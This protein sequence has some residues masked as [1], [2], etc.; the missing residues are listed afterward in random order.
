MTNGMVTGKI[1]E[2]YVSV[3]TDD[4]FEEV[5]ITLNQ[6]HIITKM[7]QRMIG[8]I[9]LEMLEKA[10]IDCIN[11]Y[12]VRDAIF[13]GLLQGETFILEI[14]ELGCSLACS[15]TPNDYTAQEIFVHTIWRGFRKFKKGI[16]QKIIQVHPGQLTKFFTFG[17]GGE[18]IAWNPA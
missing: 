4:G 11:T 9:T 6:E 16:G 14:K 8:L 15:V 7:N 1:S 18:Y 17:M 3:E 13:F 12:A 2:M 5:K 10:L